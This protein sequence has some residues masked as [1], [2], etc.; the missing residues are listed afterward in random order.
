MMT[1]LLILVPILAL[2]VSAHAQPAQWPA[3]RGPN[4]NG[5]VSAGDPPI[6]WSEA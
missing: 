6:Q 4:F 3:L 1:R 2:L 5:L